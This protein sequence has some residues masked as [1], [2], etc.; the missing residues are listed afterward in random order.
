ML[1]VYAVANPL[2][3][4]F[5]FIISFLYLYFFDYGA[6]ASFLF[7]TILTTLEAIKYHANPQILSLL[8]LLVILSI[9]MHRENI[10]RLLLG[11][12]K[13]VNLAKW[14]KKKPKD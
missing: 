4:L 11:K 12:E 1:G 8:L 10:K 2:W 9:I 3:S 7:I 13:K 5:A 14:F 6:I